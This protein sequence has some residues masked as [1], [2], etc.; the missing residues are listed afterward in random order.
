MKPTTKALLTKI[1]VICVIAVVCGGVA[2]LL[3]SLCFYGFVPRH[4]LSDVLDSDTEAKMNLRFWGAFAVGAIFGVVWSYR[5][6]KD[7]EL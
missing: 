7:M 2:G 5:M 4:M 6:V 1:S 3:F